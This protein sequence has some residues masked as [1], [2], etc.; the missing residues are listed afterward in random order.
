MRCWPCKV[1]LP[2]R[3]SQCLPPVICDFL[4]LSVTSGHRSLNTFLTTC[5]IQPTLTAL[6]VIFVSFSHCYLSGLA[7]SRVLSMFPTSCS[8][9]LTSGQGS[10]SGLV[11]CLQL[12]KKKKEGEDSEIIFLS[13]SL[14]TWEMVLSWVPWGSLLESML[15]TNFI[16]G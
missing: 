11:I 2:K 5:Q 8:V 4:Q 1:L 16:N 7:I 14:S 13:H 6:S 3:F 9:S 15:L 12:Y 10:A